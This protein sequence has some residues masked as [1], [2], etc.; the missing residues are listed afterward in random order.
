MLESAITYLQHADPMSVYLF[1]FLIAFFENVV[2]PIRE[3]CRLLLS[4]ILSVKAR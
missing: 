4:A 1:L 3:M 2:P